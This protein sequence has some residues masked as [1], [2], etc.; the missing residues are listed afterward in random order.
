[1]NGQTIDFSS[2]AEH[3]GILRS[4]NGNNMPN[5]LD[6]MS[7]HTKS[8]CAVL[9]IWM[10]RGHRGNPAASLRL[11]R[12]YGCPVL[13]SGLPSLVLSTQEI[14]VLQYHYKTNIQ[15]LQ[16]L[17]Q[18]TPECIVMF[19]AGSLPLP[20]I[21]HLR[22]LSLLG[23]IARLGPANIIYKHGI[24][25]L[26]QGCSNP[27]V[28]SWFN[29]IRLVTQQYSLPDPLL[30]LQSPPT[31]AQWKSKT[32]LRVLDWWQGKL[33]VEAE[34]LSSL[35]NSCLYR[36]HTHTANSPLEVS[37]AVVTARMLSGRYRTDKLM[38]RWSTSNPR[39]YC[40]L[41]C[42]EGNLVYIL[43]YC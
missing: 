42:C 9:P 23:M 26:L 13:L 16:R 30:V 43:L 22:Q 28:K 38:S 18:A 15:R 17:H 27:V 21:L 11:E 5:I 7:S 6:R 32:K 12:L 20:G 29:D 25:V 14:S 19:L 4:T 24:H 37:K 3:V 41:P 1:M 8:M 36:N 2:S 33:R 35:E 34:L 40:R 10:A 39:G 31:H